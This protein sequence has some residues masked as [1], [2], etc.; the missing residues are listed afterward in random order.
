MA[1][2]TQAV[3]RQVVRQKRERE[4]EVMVWPDLVFIEFVAASLFTLTFLI[5]SIF[6]NAP[7]L[8]QA[9]PDITPNPSKAPWYFMNLQEL[10]LHMHPALAGVI[11]PTIAL[12]LIAAIPYI[13]R[14]SDG[15]GVWFGTRNSVR[16]SIFSAIFAIAISLGLVL[17]DSEKHVEAVEGI[18][19]NLGDEEWK[20]PGSLGALRNVRALQTGWEWSVPVPESAQL[21][22]GEHDGELNWPADFTHIPMPFNG[23]SG[24]DWMRWDKPDWPGWLLALYWYDLNWNFPAFL[25]EI[26]L[27]VVFMVGFPV[28]L[29][30]I[31]K[32]M[33]WVVT[34]R[35]GMVALFTGFL[36]TYWTLTIIGAAFRGAGQHLKP[37]WE[38]PVLHEDPRIWAQS[39]EPQDYQLIFTAETESVIY[40][41]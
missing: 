38:V 31:L 15:Q 1:T 25:V 11:V 10:L 34:M 12:I 35:D 8:N 6:V 20:W 14:S 30:I 41:V 39:A 23:T 32:R 13:D 33:G 22:P 4:Q 17:Y 16:I 3:P 7:L 36:A 21:G 18:A 9:N 28:L 29:I 40:D 19:H 24:P 2:A 26:L 5:L 27:P 37:P